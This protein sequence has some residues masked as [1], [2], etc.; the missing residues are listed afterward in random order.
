MTPNIKASAFIGVISL[1]LVLA[2]SNAGAAVSIAKITQISG[3]AYLQSGAEMSK[4][5]RKGHVLYSGD[6]IQTKKGKVQITFN[7]GAIVRLTAFSNT[8]IQERE[9]ESGWLFKTRKAMRRITC[10]AGKLWFKSGASKRNNY[11]QTPTAVMGVR[12]SDGDFGYDPARGRSYVQMYTGDVDIEGEA[13][14]EDFQ[15]IGP[16]TADQSPVYRLFGSA[17]QGHLNALRTGRELDRASARVEALHVALQAADVYTDS[18]NTTVRRMDGLL[19]RPRVE[20]E[21]GAAQTQVVVE[22]LKSGLANAE[23][24]AATARAESKTQ[25]QEEAQ[26]DIERFV[27]AIIS[28]ENIQKKA[29]QAAIAAAEAAAAGNL[30]NAQQAAERSRELSEEAAGIGQ[31]IRR[32][33]DQYLPPKDVEKPTG[34]VEP[35]TESTTQTT[36]GPALEVTTT[37]ST[38]TTS[39]TSLQGI[40][41]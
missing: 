6:L 11:L 1:M 28:A 15:G 10:F 12:G 40:S 26:R 27:T 20:A 3:Q 19:A 4:I 2:A 35:E 17:Y 36:T 32:S 29:D 33:L 7:D 16:Q 23:R 24:T 38:S 13:L 5:T 21:I 41:P 30:E 39:S 18:P 8:R 22:E 9:E 37:T 14:R 31:E 34:K 25:A